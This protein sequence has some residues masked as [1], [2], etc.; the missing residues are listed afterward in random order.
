[1]GALSVSLKTSPSV[2]LLEM[3]H[4]ASLGESVPRPARDG[5]A[6]VPG[7]EPKEGEEGE[8][9]LLAQL[10]PREVEILQSISHGGSTGEVAG[11][12]G[13][14]ALTVQSHVKSILAKLGVHSKIQAVGLALRHGLVAVPGASDTALDAPEESYLREVGDD[15]RA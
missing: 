11:H 4:A 14:S 15:Q 6:P 5:I 3:V 9:L 8:R 1:M 7:T 13:I 12:F 10:T 2:E